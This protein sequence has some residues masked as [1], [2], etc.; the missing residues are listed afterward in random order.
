MVRI[1]LGIEYDGSRFCG[2]QTQTAGCGV[3]DALQRALAVI[4]GHPVEVVS[5]GRTDAGVHATL[6]VVHFDTVAQ[7]PDSAWVR[8]VNSFLPDSVVVLWAQPVNTGFHARFSA[9]TRSY[10]YLLLNHP[11]RPA[12]AAGRIGW[13]HAPLALEPMRAAAQ[14][15]VGTHDF[16][17]FRAAE[18]QAKSPIRTLHSLSVKQT[19]HRFSFDLSANAFLHHMVRN[20]VGALVYVGKGKYPPEWVGELLAQ[21]D[22]SRAA[23]TFAADGL[24]L[25]AV[26][27]T[28]EWGLPDTQ[29][30]DL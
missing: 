28:P 22:R 23:P 4:A 5:A 20:I 9:Q 30:I 12:I 1:A 10:R 7:R 29:R 3:Q 19:G 14:L 15:L 24:Y 26:R 25:N 21:R 6:Q 11:V 2:W 8:G 16:S 18:C 27:Y 13:F 17:A